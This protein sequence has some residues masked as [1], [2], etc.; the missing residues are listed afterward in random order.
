MSYGSS[1]EDESRE[2]A[3]YIDRIFKGAKPADLPAVQPTKYYLA[4]NLKTAATTLGLTFP[5]SLRLRID[6]L[7]E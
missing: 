2:A 4:V 1:F 5:E 7:V 3:R 6:E